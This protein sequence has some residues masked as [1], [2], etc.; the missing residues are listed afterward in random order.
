MTDQREVTFRLCRVCSLATGRRRVPLEVD[1]STTRTMLS[2]L[3]KRPVILPRVHR[4]LGRF[5][6]TMITTSPS[7][8]GLTL[9]VHFVYLVRVGR[10]SLILRCQ[11]WSVRACAAH[12]LRLRSTS[13]ATNCPGGNAAL[14]EPIK[15]VWCQCLIIVMAETQMC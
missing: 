1:M 3:G 7:L 6:L 8:I 12:H 10:Y 9:K 4:F 11:N 14:L 15:V 13:D 5:S 2:C